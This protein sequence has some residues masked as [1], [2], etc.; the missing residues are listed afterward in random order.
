[1]PTAAWKWW[2]FQLEAEVENLW[3]SQQTKLWAFK[4]PGWRLI[5]LTARVEDLVGES[6]WHMCLDDFEDQ[7]TEDLTKVLIL[8]MVMMQLA[9]I[10]YNWS[11]SNLFKGRLLVFKQIFTSP[12]S[13]LKMDDKPSQG[14]CQ[15][16]EKWHTHSHVA[17]LLGMRTVSPHV[18]T[19]TTV[20]L[21]FALSS[22]GA[23][24]VVDGKFN[25]EMFYNNIVD[26]FED[27][28]TPDDK[29]II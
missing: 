7:H 24:Q 18:I 6:D 15:R 2:I 14:K 23:W 3:G 11:Q 22:C 5:S 28:E 13:V 19:H 9:S 12:T 4:Y 1:M 16:H 21:H 27:A 17:S 29:R 8:L 26:F 10:D 20:Q 25:Y